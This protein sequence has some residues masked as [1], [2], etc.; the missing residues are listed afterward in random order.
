MIVEHGDDE[1]AAERLVALMR[2]YAVRLDPVDRITFYSGIV[3]RLTP[4]WAELEAQM[5]QD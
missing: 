4:I 1:R 3:R 5:H 2:K